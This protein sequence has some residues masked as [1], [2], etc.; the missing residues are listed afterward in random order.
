MNEAENLPPLIARL[1]WIVKAAGLDVETLVL[2]DASDDETWQVAQGLEDQYARL[3]IRVLRRYQPR[4]GYGAIV[5]YG[6]AHAIGRYC[7]LVAADGVDPIELIPDFVAHMRDGVTLV[8]CSRYLNP[9]DARTIPFKYKFYQTI[10]RTLIRLL[11]Q[12][13]IRDSTYA[14]KM[15]D[16]VYVMALGLTSNRFSISPEITFK[17]LL[18]GGRIDYIP[19]GQGVRQ[20][21][22][23]K[24]V[25]WR[26]GYG[27]ASTLLRAW[28]H[29]L[30]ILWF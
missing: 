18:S 22:A 27:Y 6:L 28:L 15:F 14:F 19:A 13:H 17:V 24:F 5:R 16:R 23:S 7:V 20:R 10:Y 26:E 11:L 12:Q 3:R 1:D 2:D 4:R 8:Q 30:G 25:F 29:R 21:G 9:G